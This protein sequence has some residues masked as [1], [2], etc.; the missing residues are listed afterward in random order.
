MSGQTA[1][2][3]LNTMRGLPEVRRQPRAIH[4]QTRHKTDRHGEGWHAPSGANISVA[5]AFLPS[6]VRAL[7]A[8]HS[9]T[10]GMKP[11]KPKKAKAPAK[12]TL[13][14]VKEK[15]SA[16]FKSKPASEA[17]AASA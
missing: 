10:H 4:A 13:K 7:D 1:G 6:K 17:K 12:R 9:K 5:P 16:L 2:R 15:L 3:E 14:S 11:E 8:C